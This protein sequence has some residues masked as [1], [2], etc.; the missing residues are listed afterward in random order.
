MGEVYQQLGFTFAQQ[1]AKQDQYSTRAQG[2]RGGIL[3]STWNEI[4]E[5]YAYICQYCGE[6]AEH[7]DHIIPWRYGGR[8]ELGNL[9]AACAMCNHIAGGKVFDTFDE[10][11][12][13]IL[14]RRPKHNDISRVPIC[15]VCGEAYWYPNRGATLFLCRECNAEDISL[16]PSKRVRTQ[17]LKKLNKL[18]RK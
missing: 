13:Y 15:T 16:L 9:V 11:R 6:D 3:T 5:H 1:K 10:K 17:N 18:L 14:S 4:M 12:A 8:D 7:V 2:K